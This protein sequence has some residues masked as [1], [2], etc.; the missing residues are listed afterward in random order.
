MRARLRARGGV[1]TKL[2]VHTG[3]NVS[4]V[5]QQCLA[6][7]RYV[8]TLCNGRIKDGPT[9]VKAPHTRRRLTSLSLRLFS[10]PRLA[11]SLFPCSVRR[12]ASLHPLSLSFSPLAPP[13]APP[14]L[15][16]PSI[17]RGH[18]PL[19]FRNALRA[20]LLSSSLSVPSLRAA[21]R[22]PHL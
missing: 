4:E 1:C 2:S 10:S 13:P 12:H 6:Y 22:A 15:A 17:F 19:S 3:A 20:V 21:N 5:L 18:L 9:P 11:T 16:H 7:I 8:L 14:C